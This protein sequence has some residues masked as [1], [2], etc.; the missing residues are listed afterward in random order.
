[1]E[2]QMHDTNN[3]LGLLLNAAEETPEQRLA[4]VTITN[5]NPMPT[6]VK[7]MSGPGM[8]GMSI[9]SGGSSSSY[10]TTLPIKTSGLAKLARAYYSLS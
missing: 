3:L 10:S 9:S 2:I 1:M 7:K 6:V 4:R 5:D 8:Q